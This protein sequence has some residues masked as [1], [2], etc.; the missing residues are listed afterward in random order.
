[1]LQDRD[2]DR[3]SLFESIENI[4][5]GL[6]KFVYKQLTTQISTEN[7][8]IIVKYIQYQKT[9]INL[10]DTYRLLVITSLITL[11]R[12]FKNKKFRKLTRADIINYLDS[13]RKSEEADPAHKWI[14]T[15]I[16]EDSYF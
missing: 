10:S 4:T 15:T 6:H 14:G 3:I 16:L 5:S 13:F 9:E 2:N 12:Y 7:A 11:V 8:D 1:M